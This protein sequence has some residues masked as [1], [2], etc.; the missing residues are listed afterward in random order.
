[1]SLRYFPVY[2]RKNKKKSGGGKDKGEGEGDGDDS[3]ADLTEE[4]V[5]K[6]ALN[7]LSENDEANNPEIVIGAEMFNDTQFMI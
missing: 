2:K 6:W 5:D 1:M 7:E 3:A 4:E